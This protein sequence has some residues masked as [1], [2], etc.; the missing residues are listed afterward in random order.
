MT[1]Q[2]SMQRRVSDN[3][4]SGATFILALKCYAF[5]LCISALLLLSFT[6]VAYGFEDPGSL[7]DSSAYI[8]LGLSSF[9]GGVLCTAQTREE[10]GRI[11]AISGGMFVA[12]LVILALAFD[13]VNSPV[14]MI[15]GYAA[16]YA[17]YI[18]GAELAWKA[19]FSKKR[20]RRSRRR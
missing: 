14:G 11:C 18:L 12:T 19:V 20:K 1:R 15:V 5:T 3:G 8:C 10:R 9:F 4:E 7:V 13:N 16:S 2:K 17:L 6:L